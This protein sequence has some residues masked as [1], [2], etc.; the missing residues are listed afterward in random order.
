MEVSWSHFYLR[1]YPNNELVISILINY[2][3]EQI[4]SDLESILN[5]IAFIYIEKLN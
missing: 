1:V 4:Q 5:E 3:N 2:R